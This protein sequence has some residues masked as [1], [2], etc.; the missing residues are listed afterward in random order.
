MNF[1]KRLL[2]EIAYWFPLRPGPIK[3]GG[4]GLDRDT[5]EVWRELCPVIGAKFIKGGYWRGS[6]VV[7]HIKPWVITLD[8]YRIVWSSSYT[9]SSD[10]YTRVRAPFVNKSGFRFRLRRR[11][12]HRSV[13]TTKS[14]VAVTEL[15]KVESDD[16]VHIDFNREFLVKSNNESQVQAVLA[17]SRLC[18]LIQSQSSIDLKIKDH[19]GWFGPSFPKIVDELCFEEKGLIQSV[20]RLESIFDL[21]TQ[22][23][24]HLCRIGSAS[25]DDPNVIL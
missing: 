6:K 10:T 7:A 21:F 22:I 23:L 25:E 18:E 20:E 16:A 9:S 2:V 12:S 1:L 24:N 15:G 13:V 5:E 19:D 4:H 3:I 14:D 8:T 11:K 17:H